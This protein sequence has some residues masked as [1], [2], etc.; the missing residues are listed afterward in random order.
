M[1]LVDQSKLTGLAWIV[2]R[3]CNGG[4]CVRVARGGKMIFIGGTGHPS[5]PTFS[6]TGP[7]WQAFVAR[8]KRGELDA[9]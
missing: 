9:P 8:I 7:E 1:E 6:F 3:W 5:G 4:D 2:S